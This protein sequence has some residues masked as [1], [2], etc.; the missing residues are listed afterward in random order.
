MKTLSITDIVKKPALFKE[1]LEEDQSVRVVWKEQKPNGE[2]VFSV[3]AKKE[4]IKN[5]RNV[6]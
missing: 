3:I 5:V 2:I 4:D 6:Q 1:A